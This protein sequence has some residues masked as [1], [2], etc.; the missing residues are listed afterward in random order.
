MRW[1]TLATSFLSVFVM[2]F[3]ACNRPH[4]TAAEQGTPPIPQVH[5]EESSRDKGLRASLQETDDRLFATLR[6]GDPQDLLPLFS[7]SGTVFEIDGPAIPSVVLER[8]FAKKKSYYCWFFDTNCM[9]KEDNE[10]RKKAGAPPS[11][12]EH[13]ALR[14]KIRRYPDRQFK[15]LLNLRDK[16]PLGKISMEHF[17][18]LLDLEN[19]RWK[20]VNVLSE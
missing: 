20:I 16:E 12:V 3:N 19:G 15:V 1:R 17:E 18:F 8:T 9:R 11:S 6:D 4:P 2:A 14:D 13:L 10:M 7:S 5:L